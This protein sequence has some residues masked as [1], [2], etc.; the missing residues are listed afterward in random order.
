M[1]KI[2]KAD[3]VTRRQALKRAAYLL[4]G[5]ISA[6][7][8]AAVLAGCERGQTTSGA[9]SALA[10]E[11]KRLVAALGERII[12]ETDT[13]GAMAAEV[14][15]FIDVMLA[16]FYPREER[17]RFLAGLSRVDATARRA[18]G[19]RFLDCTEEEQAQVVAALDRAAYRRPVDP[20]LPLRDPVTQPGHV[21][22]GR[23]APHE[24]LSGSGAVAV[25]DAVDPEDVG[26]KSFFRTLKDLVLVGYY[27]S[28]I[29]ATQ[30]LRV[31]PM[32]VFRGDIPYAEIGRVWA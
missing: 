4:G 18:Y 22:A 21:D 8:L 31:N 25:D 1:N 23:S 24:I 7:T 30:E 29:G 3:P 28:E 6:P 17:E 26:N 14:H 16:E 15:E 20:T 27:T 12:P 9:A 5:V 11:E 10:H 32:G 2:F 13:P 19:Q